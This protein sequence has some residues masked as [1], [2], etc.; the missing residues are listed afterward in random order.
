M[1]ET[2]RLKLVF[3]T[4]G[5]FHVFDQVRELIKLG[6]DVT[7]YTLAPLGSAKQFGV[8]AEN[9]VWLAPRIPIRMALFMLLR[10][11][12][13]SKWAYL[14]INDA[15]D[16]KMARI[17]PEADAF[18]SMS[19]MC[20]YSL[21]AAR[22]KGIMTILQRSS[23]HIQSQAEILNSLPG[24]EK[25]APQDI[26]RELEE[27]EITDYIT[28]LSQHSVDSFVERGV[29][30]GKL[31]KLLAGVE[32]K[33]FLFSKTET[34]HPPTIIFAGTWGMQ[35]GC[36]LLL[37]AWRK[38]KHARWDDLRLMHVGD[39]GDLGYPIDKGFMHVERVDQT[40]LPEYYQH[41]DVF[42]LASRQD[43]F[44]VVLLQALACGLRVVCSD[45]TGGPDI[46][47][48]IGDNEAVYVFKSGD[49]GQLAKKLERAL[50][51]SL[52]TGHIDLLGAKRDK[53]TWKAHA[54]SLADFVQAHR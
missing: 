44:G 14:M 37:D 22:S 40:E 1:A 49:V 4:S 24:G 21:K 28:V 20:R 47:N 54:Q 29:P 26:E 51:K 9:H 10:K 34:S 6:H 38:L 39:R 3:L 41:S 23:R 35:K 32:L 43:G 13:L 46:L 11:T 42:C 25:V 7:V 15:L 17:M 52:E 18:I 33:Q 5:R 48:E 16:K 27:Y 12:S 30:A 53:F 50:E 19:G 31:F 8:P 2:S 45:R 36:D